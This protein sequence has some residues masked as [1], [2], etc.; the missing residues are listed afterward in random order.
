MNS[1]IKEKKAPSQE[2]RSRVFYDN[3]S[4]IDDADLVIA[5]IDNFDTGTMW[6]IGYAYKAHVPVVTTTANDYG[7]NLMLAESIIGHTKSTDA[8][9]D[10]L[11]IGRSR[12]GLAE[13]L[14]E[15]GEGIAMIQSKY[16]SNFSLKEGPDERN[17]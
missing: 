3:W 5:V 16:K 15:Y 1:L 8:V 13:T 11:E 10:V 4:N 9:K 6:E 14:S 2:L 12:L 7:C 17:Q